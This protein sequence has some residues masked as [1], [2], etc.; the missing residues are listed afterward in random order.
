VSSSTTATAI[1]DNK[2]IVGWAATST[3]I[4]GFALTG[5]KYVQ[6]TYPSSIWTEAYGIDNNGNVVGSYED[7]SSKFHGF[8]RT[9]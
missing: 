8:L 1:N 6:L 4:I 2:Q 5:G 9:K 7:S 3:A